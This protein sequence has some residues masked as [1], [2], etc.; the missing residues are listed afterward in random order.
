[1]NHTIEQLI[2]RQQYNRDHNLSYESGELIAEVAEELELFAPDTHV[3]AWCDP[4]D[5][6]VKDYHLIDME[7]VDQ[8][9][10]EAAERDKESFANGKQ[11][12]DIYLIT[13]GELLEVLKRQGEV[14]VNEE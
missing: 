11:P 8:E 7:L 3:M 4:K 9:E 14:L 13:L 10:R 2:E 6:F 5:N 1:M 12:D